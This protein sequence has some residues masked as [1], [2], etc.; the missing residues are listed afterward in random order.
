MAA[1]LPARCHSCIN[2]TG[3]RR[4][5]KRRLSVL[6]KFRRWFNRSVDAEPLLSPD[7]SVFYDLSEFAAGPLLTGIQRVAYRLW[8]EW[9]GGPSLVPGMIGADGV[10]RRLS[11][12]FG[13]AMQTYFEGPSS[14]REDA[15]RAILGNAQTALPIAA[16]DFRRFAR[17]LTAEAFHNPVR[18][19]F[20]RELAAVSAERIHAV[21]YDALVVLH[22]EFFPPGA[23]E[24]LRSYVTLLRAIPNL[25]FISRA[26][27]NDYCAQVL[28]RSLSSYRVLGLG[29]DSLGRA[30]PHFLP[31][32]C[33]FTCV[34][35]VEPRKNHRAVLAAFDA[36]WRE[37]RDV[38]L[39][40][41][42][43]L[44]W[45]TREPGW[46]PYEL[47]GDLERLTRANPRFRWEREL[48]DPA[49]RQCMIE[50]RATIY[51]SE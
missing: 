24:Q 32:R 4:S 7:K 49:L 30:A 13:R 17:Y 8:R 37:G 25:H 22:P 26:A 9:P 2:W 43:K 35:T 46:R 36:L 50:S 48:G 5:G 18:V 14:E 10:P 15:T 1:I 19:N 20:Y 45:T 51:A 47:E 33:R 42:G 23:A 3:S 27:M 11:A 34:A 31:G 44:G 29:G 28:G 12:E 21:V 39:L 6:T 41:V 16:E 40:F 38:E